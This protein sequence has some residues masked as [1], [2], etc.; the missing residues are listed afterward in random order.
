MRLNHA[1]LGVRNAE[2]QVSDRP[3]S[4]HAADISKRRERQKRISSREPF[5]TM[6]ADRSDSFVHPQ[7][8]IRPS[9]DLTTL[10]HQGYRMMP[11]LAACGQ[12]TFP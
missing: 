1:Y 4:A 12:A 8:R 7:S 5:T 2:L 3:D 9:A 10:R 6:E 11:I